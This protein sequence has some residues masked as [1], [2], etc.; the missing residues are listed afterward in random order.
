MASRASGQNLLVGM[1]LG[2]Y[3]IAAKIGAGGMGEVY[4]AHDEHLDREVAIKVLPPGTLTDEGARKRFRKEALALSKLNHPNIATIHDFDSEGDIDF[5][6]ME[7]VPGKTLRDKISEGR[8]SEPEITP[9]ATQLAAGLVAA[10]ERGVVHRDLKPENVRLTLDNRVKILDFGLAKLVRATT[11]IDSNTVSHLSIVAGTLPYMAPEQVL[12]SVVD[13]RSDLFSFGIVLY[14]MLTGKLPFQ[15]DT[16]GAMSDAIL[17]STPILPSTL[18]PNASRHLESIVIKALEKDRNMRYQSASEM[19]TALK[20]LDAAGARAICDT[21]TVPA[22]PIASMRMRAARRWVALAS[23]ALLLIA[24]AG[25]AYVWKYR[26]RHVTLSSPP[27]IAVLPF[28]N[29]SGDAT[30]EYF[31]DGLSE[32]LLNDLA[33]VPGLR[34]VGRT[35]SFFF[36]GKNEDLRVIGERLNVGTLLE[37]SVRKE[38]NR[39]RITAQLV[40]AKD[41]YHVWSESYDRKMTSIFAVQDEIA[42]AVT[43]ALQEKLLHPAQGGNRR[44]SGTNNV[45]AYN[46]YLQGRQVLNSGINAGSLEAAERYLERAIHLDPRY[47][48]AWALLS[49]VHLNRALYLSSPDQQSLAKGRAEA[50]EALALDANSADAHRVIGWIKRMEWD[51]EGWRV[52]LERA[53]ALSPSDPRVMYALSLYYEAMGRRI[54]AITTLKQAVSLDPLNGVFRG[55][56]ASMYFNAGRYEEAMV[57]ARAT[58]DMYP[59]NESALLVVVAVLLAER[60][61]QQALNQALLIQEP[62]MR[63]YALAQVY[64]DLKRPKEADAALKELIQNYSANWA[65]QIGGTYAYRGEADQAFAWLERAYR[66]R[67]AGCSTIKASSDF[68]RLRSDSRYTAFLK[69]MNLPLE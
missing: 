38:G 14:E 62:E 32:E 44:A 57:Q 64:H 45:E 67:D 16:P 2:H 31:S 60:Q 37:G 65:F 56:L 35:S 13:E 51:W 25:G 17:H 63:V 48:T 21:A 69:K 11:D 33:H 49:V 40:N 6:V 53:S 3:R 34:V 47:A 58:L 22:N 29:L 59:Q 10:H 28:V 15:G 50:E 19:H 26:H 7:Y 8:L 24:T 41:G 36:K 12:G 66:Q 23:S 43:S 30:Q 5:L 27:S 20:R 54:E 1:E 39:V 55:T 18:D 42:S 52:A 4:R 46:A 68:A 61:P 9:L